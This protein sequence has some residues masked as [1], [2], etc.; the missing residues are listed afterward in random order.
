VRDHRPKNLN[1]FTIRF[2]IPAIVSILHRVS[3][4]ILFLSIPIVLWVLDYSLSS[5]ENFQHLHDILTTPFA[6]VFTWLMLAPFL[7]HFVAGIRH[8]LFDFNIGVNLSTGR[9][10]AFL[11]IVLSLILIILAGIYIW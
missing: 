4:V 7:Y 3:G 11:T 1:L 8:V 5:Q 2:P 6:K 9:L 10:S